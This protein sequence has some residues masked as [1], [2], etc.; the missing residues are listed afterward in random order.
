MDCVVRM[1]AYIQ[2]HEAFLGR[3]HLKVSDIHVEID[4]ISSVPLRLEF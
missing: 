2:S 4:E 1:P 3:I